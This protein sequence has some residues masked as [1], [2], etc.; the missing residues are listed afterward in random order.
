MVKFQRFYFS[1]SLEGALSDDMLRSHKI[2]C[3]RPL[4]FIFTTALGS[5]FSCSLIVQ[6]YRVERLQAR[7]NVMIFMGNFEEDIGILIPVS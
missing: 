2:I 4:I 5:Y 3:N 1:E 6:L 7:L